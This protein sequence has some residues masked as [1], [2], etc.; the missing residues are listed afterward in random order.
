MPVALPDQHLLAGKHVQHLFFGIRIVVADGHQAD[1][2]VELNDEL[3]LQRFHTGLQAQRH[4]VG[5]D[6]ESERGVLDH[7]DFDPIFRQNV[8]NDGQVLD[9]D[10]GEVAWRDGNQQ[11][12]VLHD[13]GWN[14]NGISVLGNHTTLV[15]WME[16]R[17][18]V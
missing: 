7:V 8:Q 11:L 5:A 2:V 4:I 3:F 12:I 15:F 6:G 16:E 9:P 18:D 13:V 17:F 14:R 1:A 10:D